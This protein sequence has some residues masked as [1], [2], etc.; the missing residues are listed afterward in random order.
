[1]STDE[2]NKKEVG[3]VKEPQ[4][5][6]L[7]Q[8]L[9]K[10]KNKAVK[11]MVATPPEY[12]PQKQYTWDP[13]AKFELTGG[14][15]GLWLNTIRSIVASPEAVRVQ[16]AMQCNEV[17]EGLM[18]QGVAKGVIIEGPPRPKAPLQKK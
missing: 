14:Q 10:P 11:Q 5:N 1:M 7:E 8:V 9:E 3:E 13:E 18:A 4:T 15:F 16:Q 6:A 2:D 12:Q 17:I